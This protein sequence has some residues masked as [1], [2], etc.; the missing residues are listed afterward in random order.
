MEKITYGRYKIINKLGVGGMGAV[1]RAHD[2]HFKRDVALKVMDRRLTHDP[3]FLDRFKREAQ[4]MAQ[5]EHNGIVTIYDYGE[6]SEELYLVMQLMEGGTLTERISGGPLTVPE[7]TRILKQ[8]AHALD[9]THQQGLVHRDL[10]PDN[11]LFNSQGAAQIG[12]FGIVKMAGSQATLTEGNIVGTPAYISPEQVQGNVHIDGR[13]DI[14]ALGVILFQM[15]TGTQ[16]YQGTTPLQVIMK[17]ITEPVPSIIR[18]NPQ[19]PLGCETVIRKAMHKNPTGRYRSVAE[20]V[21]D[22]ENVHTLELIPE[23]EPPSL[24]PAKAGTRRGFLGIALVSVI[25]A[26]IILGTA[27]AFLLPISPSPTPVPTATQRGVAVQPSPTPSPIVSPLPSPTATPIPLEAL[28]ASPTP[29]PSPTLA[30]TITPTP[31]P[32]QQILSVANV[33]ELTI[34]NHLEGANNTFNHVAI[35]PDESQLAIA[36]SAGIMLYQLPDLLQTQTIV[37]ENGTPLEVAWS[38]D[39]RYLASSTANAVLIWETTAWQA[40]AQLAGV[41]AVALAWSPVNDTLLMGMSGG[42]IQ[43][44]D[45]TETEVQ[46]SWDDHNSAITQLA[47]MPDGTSF[48]SGSGDNF[49]RIRALN[50]ERATPVYRQDGALGLAWSPEGS[51]LAMAGGDG[52]VR[53]A[54]ASGNEAG[55]L[56]LGTGLTGVVW[57]D[58]NTLATG[59]ED[60]RIHTWQTGSRQATPVSEHHASVQQ[61]LWLP[62]H[63]QLLSVG[64]RDQTMRLWDHAQ[65]EAITVSFDF[66]SYDLATVVAWSPD[67]SR[68]AVGTDNGTV[69]VWSPLTGQIIAVIGGHEET[70]TSLAWSPDGQWLATSGLPDH[71][72]RVWSAT[73]GEARAELNGHTDQV[74]AV[75]W[76]QDSAELV[77]CGFDSQLR[78]WNAAAAEQVRSFQVNALGQALAVAWAPDNSK[79]VVA[80][81]TGW[82]QI[83]PPNPNELTI[84]LDNHD[85]PVKALVWAPDGSRFVS[86]DNGGQLLVWD[87][88]VSDNGTP[89][90]TINTGLSVRHIAWSPDNTLLATTSGTT[91]RIWEATDGHLQH[92]LDNQHPFSGNAAWSPDGKYLASVGNDGHVQLWHVLE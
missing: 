39:G 62:N 7:A 27:A 52:Y 71:T 3:K 36:S 58:G 75:S 53:L 11:I 37:V 76:S 29:Q 49:V 8:I 90:L 33:T 51:V 57:L 59:S 28:V 26:A 87:S 40:T 80:G 15:L 50:E 85:A 44:W 66:V 34:A 81:Q 68:L 61:L 12:D 92:T 64:G 14:Y 78:I 82:V 19:L 24:Y 65:N 6:D 16:P 10:K 70:V 86:G 22:L 88:G 23:A 13:A 48:A 89:I 72:V 79:I 91:V 46:V 43:L 9:Y 83:R 25:A 4:V 5:I 2:P 21:T 67:S 18:A 74:T 17:H 63:E 60:G 42:Q 47:W 55:S 41:S 38:R 30:P 69:Q 77:S 54:N 84:T 73:T 20:M 32:V 35:S 45:I 1:Y 31:T 56:F